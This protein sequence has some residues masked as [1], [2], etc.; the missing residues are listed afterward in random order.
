[1]A[2]EI[3]CLYAR[4]G[5]SAYS[6]GQN[7]RLIATSVVQFWHAIGN[8]SVKLV[9]LRVIWWPHMSL[10][11][12]LLEHWWLEFHGSSDIRDICPGASLHTVVVQHGTFFV[13]REIG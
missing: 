4:F 6:W 10:V 7:I 13:E 5:L 2:R 9:G 12:V 1:M 8:Y 11:W 3:F